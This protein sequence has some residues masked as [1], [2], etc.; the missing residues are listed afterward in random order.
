MI[1]GDW[2]TKGEKNNGLLYNGRSGKSVLTELFN[3]LQEKQLLTFLAAGAS[4]A[5]PS[6]AERLVDIQQGPSLDQQ[7]KHSWQYIRGLLSSV[8][9]L[10]AGFLGKARRADSRSPWG[11]GPCR[12][13][14]YLGTV[15]CSWD[16]GH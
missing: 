13:H 3:A 11:M 9:T 14:Y 10:L 12:A 1:V 6:G 5:A 2:R 16:P 8:D 4:S 15:V 7:I